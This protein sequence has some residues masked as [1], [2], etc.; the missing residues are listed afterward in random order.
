M[1]VTDLF[2]APDPADRAVDAQAHGFGK[3]HAK[4][5]LFCFQGGVG[6]GFWHGQFSRFEWAEGN[7]GQSI[8]IGSSVTFGELTETCRFQNYDRIAP[9]I[10]KPRHFQPAGRMEA[11]DQ[12]A[13]GLM[14]GTLVR[15]ELEP[16][17]TLGGGGAEAPDNLAVLGRILIGTEG[18]A[19]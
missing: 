16:G 11:D 15:M 7:S 2:S 9:L 8:E 4:G 6:D 5:A 1:I 17:S 19:A 13:I 3:I 14:L 12:A 18:F 10:E